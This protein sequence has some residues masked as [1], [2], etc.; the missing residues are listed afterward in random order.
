MSD[1]FIRCKYIVSGPKCDKLIKEG[2]K[3]IECVDDVTEALS[4][5]GK[6]L[7][8]T[9]SAAVANA[10]EKVERPLFDVSQLNLSDAE[11]LI[12]DCLG[13]EPVH[14][15]QIIAESDLSPGSINASLISLRLKGLIKQ[16]PGN[17]FLRN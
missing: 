11:K 6:Q 7:E 10:T 12:Y 8:S 17:L 16:L 14:V 3:L 1:A 9:V 13:D 5:M 2:A 4:Y 15:E